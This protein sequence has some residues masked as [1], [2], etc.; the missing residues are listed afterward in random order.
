MGWRGIFLS[1]I[2]ALPALGAPP[3]ASNISYEDVAPIFDV[4]RPFL[5]TD[6]RIFELPT[7]PRSQA[8]ASLT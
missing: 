1:A 6:D 5:L 4:L 3:G 2:L 8:S 7:T